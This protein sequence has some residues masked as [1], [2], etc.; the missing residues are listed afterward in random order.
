MYSLL[1][2]TLLATDAATAWAAEKHE[3]NVSTDSAAVAIHE[4]GEQS[5]VQILAAGDKLDGKHLNTVSGVHSVDEGLRILLA[6]SGLTHRYVG[7][8]AVALVAAQDNGGGR[9]SPTESSGGPSPTADA[10]NRA[11]SN[12]I[13]L[14]EVVVVGSY[15]RGL[16]RPV[17]AEILT[18]DR[19]A[20]DRTGYA[21]TQDVVRT[22]PQVFGGGITDELGTI[23]ISRDSQTNV[24]RGNSINL[25]GLGGTSTLILVNGRRIAPGGLQGVFTDVSNIPL[26]AIDRIEVLPDG[27][28]ALYGSDAVGGVVNFKL[29]KDYTGAETQAR[30]GSVTDGNSKEMQF[31]QTLGTNWGEGNALLSIEYYKHD[32]LQAIDR[33]QTNSDLTRFGGQ[34]FG[35]TQCSPG[36]IT[37]GGT[38]T[39]AI[40]SGNGTGLTPASFR[41]GTQNLC[42]RNTYIDLLPENER[43]SALATV[44]QEIGDRV[45]V[46]M[47]ALYSSRDTDFNLS[48]SIANLTVTPNNA[49]YVNPMG[50]TTGNLS[51]ATDFTPVFGPRRVDGKVASSTV[52][53]GANIDVG[54]QWQLGTFVSR[55][56]QNEDRSERN[57]LLPTAAL[58]AA[59]ADRNR[60]TALNVFGDIAASNNPATLQSILDGAY[61]QVRASDLELRLASLRADGP[62]FGLPGGDVKAAVGAEY[63][64]DSLVT[65]SDLSPLNPVTRGD[66][67][68]NVKAG[69]ME[70]FVPIVSEANRFTAVDR[71]EL[72]A[73]GRY[74]EYSD[75]GNSTV[76]RVGLSWWPVNSFSVKGTWSKSYRAPSLFDLDDSANQ[77]AIANLRNS[78]T[79]T[80]TSPVL[81]IAGANRNLQ[82]E[83]AK[84]WTGGV[85]FAPASIP[86]FS[87][88]ATYF[89]IDFT[90]RIDTFGIASQ[91]LINPLAAYAV[92]LNPTLAQ[93]QAICS[94][95]TYIPGAGGTAADCLNR[96]IV[97]IVDARLSN[98]SSVQTNG[99]DLLGTYGLDTGV[100]SFDFGLNAT[101]LLEY[102]K[103]ATASA[104]LVDLV[105]T[106]TNPPEMRGRLSLGWRRG[107]FGTTLY[108]NYTGGY[109]DNI[110]VPNR[111]IDSWTTLD[112]N[113]RYSFDNWQAPVLKGTQVFL[114]A[115]NAL[116]EDPPFYNNANGV[117]YDPDNADLVGR[118]VSLFVRK[119][120]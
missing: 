38:N 55:A 59:L 81:T 53:L 66:L 63:R 102:S 60:A 25:R 45:A 76:P 14:D 15:I 108:V 47:D 68:R 50:G 5:G 93:R 113:L 82:E 58:N 49:F 119:E 34:N 103:A 112:L 44:R 48:N 1:L 91:A 30:I 29:R 73:A 96:T 67:D 92:T 74:E 52:T 120:W 28:S 54:G 69:Y 19:D 37:V 116:D 97:A 86:R 111:S 39:Y 109:K 43:K 20:I 84:I 7:D 17:G 4:F 16:D 77:S 79:A 23:N 36:T 51:V 41:V 57:P 35:Y 22:L 61:T 33:D 78:P 6:G 3:F 98:T 75:F 90:N 64:E 18:F 2:A 106:P 118:Q 104:P 83:T 26:S 32:N 27:A 40:P 13:E 94:Q 70:L 99:I 89:D 85:Q 31:A 21:T 24:S 115:L 101:Y 100:G 62:L 80:T 71:L 72:T 46:Y 56:V 11:A 10:L 87:I 42:S 114:S 65:T 95:S 105:D 9:A 107:G 117:G 110:S 8:R 88:G 12:V